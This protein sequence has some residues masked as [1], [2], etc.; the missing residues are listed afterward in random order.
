MASDLAESRLS[1]TTRTGSPW[2][3]AGSALVGRVAGSGNEL[4]KPR[5]GE[6]RA[7]LGD[8]HEW[9]IDRLEA[10]GRETMILKLVP[11]KSQPIELGVNWTCLPDSLP[12]MGPS[13]HRGLW[14]NFGHGHL[15]LTMSA[16]S[17]DILARAICGEPSNID[18]APF[19]FQRFGSR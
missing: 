15:G 14:L 7:A 3:W 9:R 8:K 17:G 19:S 5:N 13:R 2:I 6:L 11:R 18:L 12:V 1:S 10:H 16:T 4:L